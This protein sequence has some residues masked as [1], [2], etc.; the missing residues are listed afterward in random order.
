MLMQPYGTQRCQGGQPRKTHLQ[1]SVR[2]NIWQALPFSLSLRPRD[3]P[4]LALEFA[5]IDKRGVG[6]LFEQVQEGHFRLLQVGSVE[7]TWTG[8]ETF[9]ESRGCHGRFTARWY[10]PPIEQKDEWSSRPPGRRAC[11]C[12]IGKAGGGEYDLGVKGAISGQWEGP[13]LS[14]LWQTGLKGGVQRFQG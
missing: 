3:A 7:V 14:K 8:L 5:G 1:V 13:P 12:R 6:V 2:G 4:A 9:T 10:W 11:E